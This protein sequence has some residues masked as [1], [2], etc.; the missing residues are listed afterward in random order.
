MCELAHKLDA[1]CWE[2]QSVMQEISLFKVIFLELANLLI[3]SNVMK[4]SRYDVNKET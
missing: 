1:P 2:I 3:N 4:K